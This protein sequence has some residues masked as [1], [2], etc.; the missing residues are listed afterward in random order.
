MD[1]YVIESP[2]EPEDCDKIIQEISA[3]GYLHYFE[4]GCH[5]GVHTG[6]AIVETDS[7][8][9]AKQIVPWVVREKA[10]IVKLDKFQ[11]VD[12]LHPHK[13]I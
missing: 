1:R 8:E 5:D 3:A 13:K 4:W 6:W 7:P 10:R 2:H 9:H 12:P 11:N